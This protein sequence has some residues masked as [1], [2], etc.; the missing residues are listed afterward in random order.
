MTSD[1]RSVTPV[2]LQG[3]CGS[4]CKVHCSKVAICHFPDIDPTISYNL[5]DNEDARCQLPDDDLTPEYLAAYENRGKQLEGKR[6]LKVIDGNPYEGTVRWLGAKERPYALRCD[7]DDGDTETFTLAELQRY[8]L[9]DNAT[10]VQKQ[11]L[12]QA[13]Q[14]AEQGQALALAALAQNPA[15]LSSQPSPF[16]VLPESWDLTDR[17]CMHRAL[18][19]LMP[20]PWDPAHVTKL[21]QHVQQQREELQKAMRLAG[22]STVPSWKG[23]HPLSDTECQSLSAKQ[24]GTEFV[25]TTPSEIAQLMESIRWLPGDRVWDPYA[26]TGAI[27][28]AMQ[29]AR[30]EVRSSD[31]NTIL[32]GRDSIDALQPGTV[33][34]MERC[35]VVVTSPA[36]RVLDAAVPLLAQR[37]ELVCVHAPLHY[38]FDAH[39]VRRQWFWKLAEERRMQIVLC[40][41]KGPLGRRNVWIVVANTAELLQQR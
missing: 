23:R 11:E 41:D 32:T 37:R 30:V 21:A 39:P 13:L 24:W 38:V 40:R 1:T 7:Y 35:N 4:T 15:T 33:A 6:M 22:P 20:G 12:V 34:L 29:K 3:R 8:L 27:E 14:Q 26:G 10:E 19:T 2:E 9:P 36:F 17:D 18:S 28:A 25:I 16:A 5:D 31:I